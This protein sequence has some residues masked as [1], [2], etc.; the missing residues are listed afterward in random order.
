MR[1]TT[2]VRWGVVAVAASASLM[3]TACSTTQDNTK[4][5][6]SSSASVSPGAESADAATPL[7][8]ATDRPADSE[9][10]S[11]RPTATPYPTTEAAPGAA[12]P[13]VRDSFAVLQA[14]YNDSC[15]TEGNCVYFLN[16]LITNLDDLYNSMKASPREPAHFDVPVGLIA[17]LQTTLHG[18]FSYA[19]LKTHRTLLIS[20]RDKVNTW[21]QGHPEDYR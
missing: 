1:T 16:R 3:L 21:M 13:A 9:T 8:A 20:T 15:D 12:V 5:S 18:D 10:S 14:T 19:N 7:A 17:Q 4:V 11:P 6:G 2:A